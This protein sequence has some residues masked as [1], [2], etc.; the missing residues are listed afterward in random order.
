MFV[1]TDQ[2]SSQKATPSWAL[3]ILTSRNHPMEMHCSPYIRG[4]EV[5]VKYNFD[6]TLLVAVNASV[7][8]YTSLILIGIV[9][10]L[11]N[12]FGECLW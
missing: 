6:S 3:R 12:N 8:Q 9:I 7:G 1:R 5:I 11:F 2:N 10:W 4:Y